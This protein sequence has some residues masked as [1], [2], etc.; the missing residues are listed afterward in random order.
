M[1]FSRLLLLCCFLSGVVAQGF[2]GPRTIQ[3]ENGQEVWK[4]QVDRD[5]DEYTYIVRDF[6]LRPTLVYNC[7]QAPS[8][9]KTAGNYLGAGVTTA[10]LH[11]DNNAIRKTARRDDS[12]PGNWIDTHDC[13]APDQ[14]QWKGKGRDHFSNVIMWRDKNGVVDRNRIADHSTKRLADGTEKDIYRFAGAIMSCDE[15][16][17]A[18]WIEGGTGAQQYCAPEG[19]RCGTKNAVRTDQDWQ[20]SGHSALVTWF[21]SR[22]PDEI[23]DDDLSYTIFKF[24]FRLENKPD[25]AHAVWVEARGF[26]RYCYGPAENAGETAFCKKVWDGDTPEP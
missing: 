24:D 9:C 3:M 17:A 21:H 5:E 2:P 13:P 23:D 26:K 15:W 14:P 11:Y 20:A 16:P 22:F 4:A 6:N 1:V 7:A 25:D 12:C 10:T 19:R 18:S 8:L